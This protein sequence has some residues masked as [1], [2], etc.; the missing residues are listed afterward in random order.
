MIVYSIIG[1]TKLTMMRWKGWGDDTLENVP[2]RESAIKIK[3]VK[4]GYI[5]TIAIVG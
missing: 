1:L 3:N 5:M 4:I 2:K